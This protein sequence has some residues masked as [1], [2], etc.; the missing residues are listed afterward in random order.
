M[1]FGFLCGF[2]ENDIKCKNV[3]SI[4]NGRVIEDKCNK[5]PQSRLIAAG[6]TRL[7]S[8]F[9]SSKEKSTCVD[10]KVFSVHRFIDLIG[11]DEISRII[12][13]HIPDNRR[14]GFYPD[15]FFLA[16]NHP[17]LPLINCELKKHLCLYKSD[18]M[19]AIAESTTI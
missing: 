15:Y 4:V 16:P 17:G 1:S 3:R 9:N 8:S 13:K 11:M 2:R 6:A 12:M 10:R 18:L 7:E 19:A 5:N 14:K